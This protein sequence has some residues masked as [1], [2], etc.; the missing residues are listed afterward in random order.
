MLAVIIIYVNLS[1]FIKEA[2]GLKSE[3]ERTELRESWDT[4]EVGKRM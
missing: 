1:L 4:G 2:L 3:R